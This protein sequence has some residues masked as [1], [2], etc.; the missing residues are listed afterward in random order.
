MGL[1]D[2]DKKV[3]FSKGRHRVIGTDGKE[4]IPSWERDDCWVAGESDLERFLI[5]ADAIGFEYGRGYISAEEA[6]RDILYDLQFV[7]AT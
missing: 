1:E 3:W 5:H 7:T 6:L 2:N 4:L